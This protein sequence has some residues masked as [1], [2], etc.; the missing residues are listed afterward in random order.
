MRN[1]RGGSPQEARRNSPSSDGYMDKLERR[2]HD[3]KSRPVID[4]LAGPEGI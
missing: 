3:R 4:A 2:V 1:S